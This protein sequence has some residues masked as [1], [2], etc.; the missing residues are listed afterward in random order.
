M[1]R[2]FRLEAKWR[3]TVAC[4]NLQETRAMQTARPIVLV[5]L[6]VLFTG[7]QKTYY[8]AW[9]KLGYEKRDILVSRVEK[10]RDDQTA[11]KDQI[12]TTLQQFQEVTGFQ[13]G[14]LEAKY[15][16]LDSSYQK[17]ESRAAE[18]RDRISAVEST[19]NAMFSEWKDELKEYKNEQLRAS[20]QQQLDQTKAH[21]NEL[22]GVM[23]QAASKMDPVLAAF[24]DQVLFLK[25]N[26]N[27]QAIASLQGTASQIQT[28]VAALIK[29]MEASIAEANEFITAMNKK[30]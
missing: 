1:G 14:N 23:K 5:T 25:H 24:K 12:K 27:A 19:A 3:Y 15:K 28:D 22:I 17:A 2:A 10:A 9:E 18:V 11:A 30:G 8:K 13:G 4:P 29:D 7:C 26:L 20:S 21:Y 16:K 6:L